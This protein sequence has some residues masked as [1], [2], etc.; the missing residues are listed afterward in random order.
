[1]SDG[2][3]H[4]LFDLDR[5][6]LDCN[7]GR[8]WMMAEWRAGHIGVRDVAWASWWLGRY[9]LGNDAG[10]D[11]VFATAVATLTGSEEQVLSDRVLAWFEAEVRHRLRPGASAALQ[12]HRDA[13]HRLVLATSSTQYVARCAVDA[14]GLHDGVST[15]L[16]VDAGRF[17]GGIEE[18]AVGEAKLHAVRRW[19]EG[20]G[21]DLA[22]CAF[23][24][25]SMSDLALLEAVGEP[26]VV[27]PDRR[28]AAEARRRGW[29]V[30]KW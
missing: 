26:V 12:R 29:R 8:L 19:A 15:R 4:A 3:D 7:S 18:L 16:A 21:V 28:L 23:Y 22:R 25:D 9:A 24:T 14:Y 10:L 5:T 20:Q 27:H 11:Q 1:V 17:T 2:V 30:E 13:G 6:L